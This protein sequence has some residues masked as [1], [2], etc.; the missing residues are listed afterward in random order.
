[1]GNIGINKVSKN[2]LASN[3]FEIVDVSWFNNEPKFQDVAGKLHGTLMVVRVWYNTTIYSRTIRTIS[4]DRLKLP[5]SWVVFTRNTDGVDRELA[6]Y[7]R[8]GAAPIG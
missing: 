2:E 7:L 5:G 4:S 6:R 1:M 8:G 3:G